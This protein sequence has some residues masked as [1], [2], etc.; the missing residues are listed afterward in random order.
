MSNYRRSERPPT[1]DTNELTRSQRSGSWSERIPDEGHS[2]SMPSPKASRLASSWN[3]LDTVTTS[4]WSHT[5]TSLTKSKPR[6]WIRWTLWIDSMKVCRYQ[7]STYICVIIWYWSRKA[8]KESE[9]RYSDPNTECLFSFLKSIAKIKPR[10]V[11][12]KSDLVLQFL[13]KMAMLPK[14]N[15]KWKHRSHWPWDSV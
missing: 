1:K 15:T 9:T 7:K 10:D 4:P 3:G 12:N 14:I 2:L 5:L 11:L 6:K 13:T 8:Y